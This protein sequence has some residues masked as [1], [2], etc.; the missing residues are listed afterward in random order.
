[1]KIKAVIRDIDIEEMEMIVTGL[2]DLWDSECGERTSRD[3]KWFKDIEALHNRLEK[4]LENMRMYNAS[5]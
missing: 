1:M 3:D 2:A 5:H 4:R